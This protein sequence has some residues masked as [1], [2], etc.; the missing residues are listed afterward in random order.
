MS[1][2]IPED[3]KEQQENKKEEL[4]LLPNTKEH[5]QA[6]VKDCILVN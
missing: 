6:R 4:S 1:G 2:F 5:I 3:H